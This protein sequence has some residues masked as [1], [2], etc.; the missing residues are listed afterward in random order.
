V[1]TG[2]ISCNVTAGPGGICGGAGARL[3][4]G[5]KPRTG[6]RSR[7]L[8]QWFVTFRANIP[9]DSRY[10]HVG[11][12]ILNA[13]GIWVCARG[14]IL[15]IPCP[16]PAPL[17][18]PSGPRQ[19]K[20]NLGAII[21][22]SICGVV[23]LAL[24]ATFLWCWWQSMWSKRAPSTPFHGD[25]PMVQRSL[26][27]SLLK[28][29]EQKHEEISPERITDPHPS[30]RTA[31]AGSFASS[32]LAYDNPVIPSLRERDVEAEECTGASRPVDSTLTAE[33]A[34]EDASQ[35]VE[36]IS[37]STFIVRSVERRP[38]IV[39]SALADRLPHSPIPSPTECNGNEPPFLAII[40]SNER[41][42]SVVECVTAEDIP[43][44]SVRT[45]SH[46][47]SEPPYPVAR[48][49]GEQFH[50]LREYEMAEDAEPPVLEETYVGGRK[51][52]K[53]F[54]S[55]D[56]F[57]QAITANAKTLCQDTTT[58]LGRPENIRHLTLHQLVIYC[59]DSS[60]MSV[61]SHYQKQRELVIRIARIATRIVPDYANIDVCFINAHGTARLPLMSS[62]K[63]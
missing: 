12:A 43:Q 25:E 30:S 17:T 32:H 22:G 49:P 39:A 59:D 35:P 6:F 47:G 24:V 41:C 61:D 3:A 21:G 62:H 36:P 2:G 5:C 28:H 31:Q 10:C 63:P 52:E 58:D 50:S 48:D 37:N 44:P 23:T 29:G 56:H 34:S 11:S 40:Q 4:T 19:P 7:L 26:H 27:S 54:T 53:F 1:L 9:R 14:P 33:A 42:S 8:C 46:N 13:T 55:N 18:P 45:Q 20:R 57:V 16:T 15:K 38:S 51:F 60:S